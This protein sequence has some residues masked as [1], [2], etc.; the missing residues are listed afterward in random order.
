[1]RKNF[2]LSPL[3]SK[4]RCEYPGLNTVPLRRQKCKLTQDEC[5]VISL[6]SNCTMMLL[7]GHGGLL[8]SC[9]LLTVALANP[10]LQGARSVPQTLD[11]LINGDHD[12]VDTD[13][14]QKEKNLARA[15]GQ[16]CDFHFTVATENVER[17]CTDPKLIN[18]VEEL[19]V[20]LERLRPEERSPPSVKPVA[21]G[22][23]S[24]EVSALKERMAKLETELRELQKRALDSV[25]ALEE[26]EFT[27]VPNA[28]EDELEVLSAKL[29]RGIQLCKYSTLK[30]ATVK[31]VS[32]VVFAKDECVQR[33]LLKLCYLKSYHRLLHIIH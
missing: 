1:M 26:K 13:K 33:G 27:N 20:K 2:K 8:T 32:I 19:E 3:F 9:W 16:V 22:N 17:L 25:A 15:R 5:D 23:T 31:I 29:P 11:I 6:L 7:I 10:S 18:R 28:T 30:H 4:W 24:A 14:V 21:A 12:D